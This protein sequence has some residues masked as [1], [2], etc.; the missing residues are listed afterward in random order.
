MKSIKYKYTL[1][2]GLEIQKEL[3]YME[4]LARAGWLDNENRPNLKTQ[5]DWECMLLELESLL[6]ALTPKR[7]KVH[8]EYVAQVRAGIADWL[9]TQN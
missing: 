5:A 8:R 2:I 7:K 6:I 3:P 1:P 4:A 9:K